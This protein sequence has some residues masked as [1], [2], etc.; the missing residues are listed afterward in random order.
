M[1]VC[2]CNAITDSKLKNLIQNGLD[3]IASLQEVCPV[4]KSCGTC[5]DQVQDLIL[6]KKEIE[7]PREDEVLK[8]DE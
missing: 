6:S 5:L 3:S 1:Y 8:K 4:G 2:L 7:N